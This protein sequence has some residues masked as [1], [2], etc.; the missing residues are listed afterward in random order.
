MLPEPLYDSS[1][2]FKVFDVQVV[3]QQR[4]MG[5]TPMNPKVIEGWLRKQT[6][7]SDQDELDSMIL[8]TLDEIGVEYD[9]DTPVDE[10]IERVIAE[11]SKHHTNGFKVDPEIGLY[12]E[13]RYV[14]AGL[15][16]AI[17]IRYPWPDHK[18]GPT[19]K[20]AKSWAVER[21][22]V[23]PERIP[24]GCFEPDGVEL[25]T[26]HLSGPQGRRSVL[27]NFQFVEHTV[28]DFELHVADHSEIS[29]EQWMNIWVQFGMGGLGALR[30]Q[31]HGKCYVSKF[32]LRDGK[33]KKRATKK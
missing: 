10:V 7:V 22:C 9:D 19:R 15:R 14:M 6:K 17:S 5:G 27:T 24:L 28:L 31:Q 20:T 26:G 25:F 4:L 1:Q 2:V 13:S 8:R 16:E 21:F 32:D 30:S 3:M 11:R 12:I 33:K 23:Y 18:W 29:D